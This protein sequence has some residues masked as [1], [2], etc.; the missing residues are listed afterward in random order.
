MGQAP[1]NLFSVKFHNATDHAID[2]APIETALGRCVVVFLDP[3]MPPGEY[4]IRFAAAAMELALYREL[5]EA[6]AAAAAWER[7]ARFAAGVADTL[8]FYDACRCCRKC[9]YPHPCAA[10]FDEE[11][12]EGR[13]SCGA[14]VEVDP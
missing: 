11:P 1:S 7:R 9:G 2:I 12:C 4:T 3:A 10:V 14:D 5:E 13:C 8:M 6:R